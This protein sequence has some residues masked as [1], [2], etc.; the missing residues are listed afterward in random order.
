MFQAF[1]G[2]FGDGVFPIWFGGDSA[3]TLLRV[4]GGG[5]RGLGLHSCL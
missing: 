1:W 3:A 2:A 5:L 4:C